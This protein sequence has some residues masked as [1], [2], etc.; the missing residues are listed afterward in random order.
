MGGAREPDRRR[1]GSSAPHLAPHDVTA[2]AAARHPIETAGRVG[3][4]VKGVLYAL[5]GVLAV[6]TARGGGDTEGQR[7][8][9]RTVAESP[10]GDV[11]LLLIGLGLGAYGLWRLALAA[12]DPEGKGSDASGLAHRAGYVLSGLA[13][14][15]LAVSAFRIR[16]AGSGDSG[17]A[18]ERAQTVLDLPGGALLVG[19]AALGV[20]AYAVWEFV[21][22]HR[23]DFMDTFDLDGLAARRRDVVRRIGQAGLAA[24]GVV[25]AVIGAFLLQTAWQSDSSEAR[26]LD[27][28]LQAL[29]DAPYGPWLLGAVGLGLVAYGLYCGVNALYRRFEGAQ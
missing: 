17:G 28:A 15:G 27:G 1:G 16:G 23:A 25:Y 26:G 6:Q 5:L 8:A 20:L 10:G 12:L 24:R 3:Y 19:L 11:L 29:R 2:S 13:Y 21:R 7:G 18:Q 22:A 4:A 9:L 14:L